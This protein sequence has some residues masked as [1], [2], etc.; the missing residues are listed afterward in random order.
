MNHTCGLIFGHST[1]AGHRNIYKLCFQ[2]IFTGVI[3]T[4]TC[5]KH[6]NLLGHLHRVVDVI[7]LFVDDAALTQTLGHNDITGQPVFILVHP[8][9]RQRA[10]QVYC[11]LQPLLVQNKVSNLPSK[12]CV[13]HVFATELSIKLYQI[14]LLHYLLTEN[15]FDMV[16]FQM[17]YSC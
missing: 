15:T 4:R 7:L 13:N 6:L 1:C 8:G 11:R 12:I 9:R 3:C 5:V 14:E 10:H 17:F 16:A 2:L